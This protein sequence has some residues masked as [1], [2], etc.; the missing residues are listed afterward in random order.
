VSVLV[1]SV[2]RVFDGEIVGVA[3][4]VFVG[5][6]VADPP[7]R[8]SL[9]VTEGVSLAVRSAVSDRDAVLV[10]VGPIVALAVVV[11]DCDLEE[12][13]VV[14]WDREGVAMFVDVPVPLAVFVGTPLVV[15]E[16]EADLVGTPV[17]VIVGTSV[18]ERLRVSV[19]VGTKLAVALS[20]VET[21]GVPDVDGVVAAVPVELAVDVT[22]GTS[23]AV[24]VVLRVDVSGLDFVLVSVVVAVALSLADSDLVTV[25]VAIGVRDNDEL[26]VCVSPGL[27]VLET[28]A[29][30]VGVRLAPVAVDVSVRDIVSAA[31][32]VAL[33]EFESVA[34]SVLLRV[35]RGVAVLDA[36]RLRVCGAVTVD[37]ARCVG[38]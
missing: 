2:V 11:K 30:E 23:D 8:V 1:G 14:D 24:C 27:T 31:V 15:S 28:V 25:G 18:G 36:D 22:V 3:L 38:D 4:N 13:D 35:S 34:D 19:G 37:V 12:L 21:D 26:E 32:F 6:A 29:D 33:G 7:V 20:V 5:V 16:D 17:V 10:F 9:A